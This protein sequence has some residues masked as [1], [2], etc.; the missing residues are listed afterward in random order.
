MKPEISKTKRAE[1]TM[2]LIRTLVAIVMVSLALGHWYAGP[3]GVGGH[4][5]L[6]R[7]HDPAKI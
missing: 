7:C 5:H 6:D 4:I 2:A 3:N 1:L